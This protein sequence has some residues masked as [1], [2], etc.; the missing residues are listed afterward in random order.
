MGGVR[1]IVHVVAD[2]LMVTGR[3]LS[4]GDRYLLVV[5]CPLSLICLPLSLLVDV[6]ASFS[7]H[8]S[9]V[10][11]R[12]PVLVCLFHKWFGLS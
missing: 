5:F 8:N 3:P 4:L 1:V 7:L 2:G 10:R 11:T 6:S 9:P 12:F